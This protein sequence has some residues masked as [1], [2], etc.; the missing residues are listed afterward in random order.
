MH[1]FRPTLFV[2]LLSTLLLGACTGY[3][4]L[5]KSSDVNKKYEAAIQYYEKG[6]YF[7]AG[8]LL[9]DLLPLLKGRP[10]AEKAQFYFAN[11]NFRQRNYTLGAYYF[12]SFADTYP[13]SQYAEEANFLQA[14]SLF[15][16]SPEWELDQTN[17]YSALESIQEFINRYPT[18]TFRPEAESMS[19]ELQKKL[20]L[21]AYQGAKLYYNLRYYQSAVVALGGFQQQFPASA[22]NEEAEFLKVSAQYDLARESVEEKQRERYLEVQA[23]YQHFIDTYPQSRRLKEAE[24][25]FIDAQA[26]AAKLKPADPTAAK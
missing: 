12:K 21:K 17:T 14:K 13:N 24:K 25:M 16:D 11:T 18:S 8:T 1:Y 6:D 9:E 19:Q 7:K 23:F 20:E 15:R 3:Q 4:K 5:L 10:E 22:F 2:L 26:Q